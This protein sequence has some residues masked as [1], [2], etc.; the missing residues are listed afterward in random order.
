MSLAPA[1]PEGKAIHIVATTS[2]AAQ[3]PVSWGSGIRDV[4]TW[5]TFRDQSCP[6]SCP[7]ATPESASLGSPVQTP[8]F[9]SGSFP[10]DPSGLT[11]LESVLVG[12]W[13]GSG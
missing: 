9:Y 11:S 7:P 2:W 10:S 13:S 8:C 5:S 6:Q 4:R 12:A 3:R 1:R